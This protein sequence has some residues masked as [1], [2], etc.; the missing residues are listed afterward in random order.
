MHFRSGS[1]AS[2]ELSWHVGF[3]PQLRT[4]TATQRTDALGQQRSSKYG[5]HELSFA[6]LV[7]LSGARRQ[8]ELLRRDRMPRAGIKLG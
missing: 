4:L 3:Y 1:N 8:S 6:D 7:A 5:Y 2:V